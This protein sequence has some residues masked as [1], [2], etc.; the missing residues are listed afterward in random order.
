MLRSAIENRALA[1]LRAPVLIATR[2]PTGLLVPAVF[3][4]D[5]VSQALLALILR[6]LCLQ[7]SIDQRREVQSEMHGRDVVRGDSPSERLV[8][9]VRCGKSGRMIFGEVV[10]DFVHIWH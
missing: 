5:T 7:R 6:D 1:F 4:G 2:N 9:L 3:S 8:T 10:A